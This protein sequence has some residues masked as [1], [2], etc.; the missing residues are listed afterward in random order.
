MRAVADV[1]HAQFYG[2]PPQS[3]KSRRSRSSIRKEAPWIG[4]RRV[5]PLVEG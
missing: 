4:T 1:T 2:T 5:G 3:Y